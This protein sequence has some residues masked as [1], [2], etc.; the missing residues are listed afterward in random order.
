MR[1]TDYAYAV[2]RIRA[3]EVRLLPGAVLEEMANA[4]SYDAAVRRLTEFGWTD[5]SETD[6][7]VLLRTESEKLWLLMK[8]TVGDSDHL[9]VLTALNDFYNVKA[10][11]KSMLTDADPAP[12]YVQPTMLDLDA[13]TDAV[14]SH[15]FE[16][17]G[18][19]LA[20]AAKQ[21]Y[22]AATR[23]ESG[24]S[25]DVLIDAA[26][27]QYLSKQ[28]DTTDCKLLSQILRFLCDSTNIKV[29][30]RCARTGKDRSFVESAVGPCH[31]L[32]RAGLCASAVQGE[33]QLLELLSSGVYRAGAEALKKSTTAFEKWCDDSVI[34]L[35]KSA[36]FEFFGFAPIAAYYFAK[37]TEIKT[38]RIVLS[39]KQAGVSNDIIRERVRDLYV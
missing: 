13:L 32:D 29:A 31:Q 18:E 1:D 35:C 22:E 10:A 9:R 21:A 39:A 23:T 14:S 26:T 19:P 34:E 7:S 36:K 12:Y 11:L 30:V 2:A 4:P 6:L 38:V 25:A 16:K 37:I 5:G 15:T 3:N 20:P 24:Q 17:L 28:A 8:E 33:A 27:L